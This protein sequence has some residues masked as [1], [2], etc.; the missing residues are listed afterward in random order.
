MITEFLTYKKKVQNVSDGTI[1]EYRKNLTA[2]A[3]WVA[4]NRPGKGWS[5]ITKQDIEAHMQMM[6]DA[7]MKPRTIQLRVAAIRSLYNWLTVDGKMKNS[8]AKYV[9]MPKAGSQLPQTVELDALTAYVTKPATTPRTVEV[10]ALT[11]IL[12]ETGIRLQEAID[13]R[14]KDIN[15]KE[16]SIAITGKGNK[17]RIVYYGAMTREKMNAL[18]KL[19]DIRQ[20]FFQKEQRAYREAMSEEFRGI[21]EYIHPHMLRHTFAT[22]MLKNGTPLKYL[23]ELLGHEHVTTTERYTH[24]VDNELRMR[25]QTASPRL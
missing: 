14:P 18:A 10:Q 25:A 8:P 7:K 6:H 21:V 15:K 13:I 24:A 19:V 12:I 9:T 23:S 22:T 2:F 5:N 17:Q 4:S 16:M 3:A 20:G 1:K 11:A